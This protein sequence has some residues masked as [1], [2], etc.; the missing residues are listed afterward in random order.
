[1]HFVTKGSG[2]DT[3]G[4]SKAVILI[5]RI[6]FGIRDTYYSERGRAE[7]HYQTKMVK[8]DEPLFTQGY[9]GRCF[10][11]GLTDLGLCHRH[12]I[13]RSHIEG[14]ELNMV[15]VSDTTRAVHLIETR[16]VFPR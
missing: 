11:S 8:H 5:G 9:P 7:N 13:H 2:D 1:M 4:S 15:R 6:I 12:P 16:G 3:L 14:I 10:Y